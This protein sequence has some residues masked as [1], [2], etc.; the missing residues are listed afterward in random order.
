MFGLTFD[1]RTNLEDIRKN[2]TDLQKK[3]LPK[4]QLKAA[5]RAGR[6][7][8]GALRSEMEEKFDE[9]T[10]WTLDG[11]RYRKPTSDKPVVSIW[12]EEFAGKGIPAATF[13]RAEIQGGQRR[14]KRFEQALIARGFMPRNMY[15]V[16]GAQ[17]PLDSHGNVPGSFIV[18]MLSDLQAFGESGYRANRKGERKGAR[19]TNY[20]FVPPKGGRLKPGVYWHM[21]NR[22]LGVVFRFVTAAAY[23][24]RYDFYGVGERA[25][26]RVATRF[27]TE[28]LRD[29]IRKD[30]H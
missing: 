1:I 22:M 27:M 11:L 13:L 15:A 25:Y 23:D 21:P 3:H 7:V 4:A 8:F 24:K 6:Y 10:K 18:R 5:D 17:A 16:P 19:R 30:N 29:L 14:H 28:A 12:L 26:Q 2:I 9:P 20:F